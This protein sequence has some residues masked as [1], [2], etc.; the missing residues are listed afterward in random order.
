VT[1]ARPRKHSIHPSDMHILMNTVH[2][3]SIVKSSASASWLP[4]CLPK[5]NASGFVNVFVSF[6]PD[7]DFETSDNRKPNPSEHPNSLLTSPARP[8]SPPL[9][10]SDDHNASRT[11][12]DPAEDTFRVNS[13]HNVVNPTIGVICVTASGDFESIRSWV[14]SVVQ[15]MTT[16][17]TIAAITKDVK[18]GLTEYSCSGLGIPGLRHFIYKSRAH[19]QVTAPAYEEPYDKLNERRRLLTLYHILYDNI[20]GKSGQDTPLKLQYIRTEHEGVL[21]W[22]TQPFELYIAVSPRLP[23]SAVIG[24]A[25]AVARWIKKEEAQI[26]LRDAPVF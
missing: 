4:I 6:L 20:H 25:N 26:F 14:E 23:K 16:E 3:P 13:D 2:S 24:A 18:A 12:E 7:E 19:V 15:R 9:N 8:A 17:G 11:T 21:G 5:F 22:I 1:L 10:D